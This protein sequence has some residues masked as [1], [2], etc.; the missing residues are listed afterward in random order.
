MKKALLKSIITFLILII[1]TRTLFVRPS[2]AQIEEEYFDNNCVVRNPFLTYF[3]TYGDLE[4]FG[5]PI[6]NAFVDDQGL[7]MQYF[8]KARLEWHPDNPDPY[9]VQLGLLGDELNY[10]RPPILEPMPRS[11]RRIYFPE[12]GHSVV[13]AFLDFFQ[14]HGGIDLFGYPIT[15]MHFEDGKIVQYFQRL[16]MEWHPEN[17]RAPVH[18]A[19][20]GELCV[21]IDICKVPPE[22]CAEGG[23]RPYTGI[24]ALVSLK[25]SVM[26]TKSDQSISVLVTDKHGIVIPNAQV[27]IHLEYPNGEML[28][29]SA[30]VLNTDQRGFVRTSVPVNTALTGSQ[31]IVKAKVTVGDQTTS[32]QNVFLLW[33]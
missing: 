22:G 1:L 11:R 18:I 2:V 24:R 10:S 16:K 32:A 19:D 12:T 9:K 23:D 4:I 5:Y 26:S 15:E 28:E 33:W 7:L 17:Q 14:T 3:R 21:N 20:L 30:Y 27:A 6:T 25:Y 29:G 8:Q 31:V 13:Y